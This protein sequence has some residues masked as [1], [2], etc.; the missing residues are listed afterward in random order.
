MEYFIRVEKLHAGY[1][2]GK[3]SV[4]TPYET[5]SVDI[6]VHQS[7]KHDDMRGMKGMIAGQ[8]LK[9]YMAFISGKTQVNEWVEKAI[10]RV[11]Q[12]LELDSNNEHYQLLK[13]HIYLRG[14]RE[15]EAKWILD[16]GSYSKFV[17]GRKQEISAYYMFLTAL[18]KKDTQATVRA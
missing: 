15:E 9:E 3:I 18:L 6:I 2:Y 8:G 7:G 16:N 1:N 4:S 11:D 5:L 10:K 17:I 13:A 14:R 12:L